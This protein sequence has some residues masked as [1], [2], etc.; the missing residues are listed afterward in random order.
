MV[1]ASSGGGYDATSQP[2]VANGSSEAAEAAK[3]RGNDYFKG[4]EFEKAIEAYSEAIELKPEE[5]IYWL[6]RS[7]AHRQLERWED[8]AE[9]AAQAFVLQPTN[10]KAAFGRALCLQ[11]L[12]WYEAAL[13]AAQAGLALQADNAALMQLQREVEMELAKS[14]RQQATKPKSKELYPDKPT[15]PPTPD[16]DT[17]STSSDDSPRGQDGRP[18]Y[19]KKKEARPL[20]EE[21]IPNK[22]LCDA[23][24]NGDAQE[25]KR[26]LDAGTV[27]DVNWGRPEDGNTA[28]HIAAEEGHSDLVK[29]LLTKGA[30]VDILNDFGL[31]A[32]CLAEKGTKAHR[33]LDKLTAP[34]GGEGRRCALRS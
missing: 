23:A 7:L 16:S 30:S 4:K 18:L 20:T 32:V 31:K 26:L 13:E 8:G 5:G 9:D 3:K 28:L 12:R 34:L 22:E 17:E 11:K 14:S 15:A 1:E 27:K 19:F 10:L 29:Q 21:E 24:K 6:N 33:I 25:L 2:P